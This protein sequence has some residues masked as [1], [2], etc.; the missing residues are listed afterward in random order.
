[1]DLQDTFVW[2]KSYSYG[3]KIGGLHDSGKTGKMYDMCYP[4][5][6]LKTFDASVNL[7]IVKTVILCTN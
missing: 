1:M 3:V 7:I 4:I 5:T 2:R 6:T